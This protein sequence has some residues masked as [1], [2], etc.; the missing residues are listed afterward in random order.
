MTVAEQCLINLKRIYEALNMQESYEYFEVLKETVRVCQEMS[1]YVTQNE[2][3]EQEGER[4]A[5]EDLLLM[6]VNEITFS[7]Y[8]GAQESIEMLTSTYYVAKA[9]LDSENEERVNQ[10]KEFISFVEGA[11]SLTPGGI[12]ALNDIHNFENSDSDDDATEQE[13]EEQDGFDL[14]TLALLLG[15]DPSSVSSIEDLISMV[16]PAI[17]EALYGA[18]P[19]LFDGDDE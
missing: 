12:D 18:D 16:D 10:G 17:L 7:S 14:N 6:A 11:L 9:M 15:I 5:R 4:E 19:S 3:T 2:I 13:G 1:E 8:L